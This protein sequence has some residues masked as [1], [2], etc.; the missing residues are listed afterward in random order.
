MFEL[1]LHTYCTVHIYCLRS[2]G[3]TLCRYS[4][5]LES[6]HFTNQSRTLS[7]PEKMNCSRLAAVI[8]FVTL[9]APNVV[10]GQS[11]VE[12]YTPGECLDSQFL[13][14][15]PADS[16]NDCLAACQVHCARYRKPKK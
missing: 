3:R 7:Y 5:V 11:I 9:P 6:H 1:C 14:A 10:F 2:I 13:T 4:L 16:F 8:I 15:V 12:C